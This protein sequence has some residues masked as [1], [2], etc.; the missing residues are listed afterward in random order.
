VNRAWLAPVLA[1]ALLAV[2]VTLQVLTPEERLPPEDRL[3]LLDIFFGL[4]FVGYAAVGALIVARHPRNA[5]GWLFC[6]VGVALPVTSVFYAYATYGLITD[7][8]PADELAAWVFA[9]SGDSL[10]ILIV[11][12][13][14]LFP[15]G[16]F[17]SPGWARFGKATLALAAFSAL[18]TA[19]DPGP[20]YNFDGVLTVVNP[21]GVDAAA[22]VLDVLGGTREVF[23][24]A[25][26]V[27]AVSL[28]A[29]YRAA[30]AIERQQIKWLAAAVAFSAVMVLI[31]G[32]LEASIE[33]FEG[34]TEVV[35]SM[36]ALL[37]LVPIP[38]GVA[39][40]MLRH[41][42]YDVDVVI[43]RTLI[44]AA[45]TATLAAGYLGCVL[46]AQVII[47]AKSSFAIAVSTLAMAALFRPARARIQELVDRRFFR[48]RYDAALTL[49]AFGGRLRDELDLDAVGADLRAVARETMQ[50]AHVSLWLRGAP[51]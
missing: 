49:E 47:G 24:V 19:L 31:L 26:V 13:M 27:A 16:R 15:T 30:G 46:L 29:R 22:G 11:L 37:A 8:L 51:R 21:L 9:W 17:A 20:L 25:F 32:V 36:V 5:V 18:V 45:L 4:A 3:D 12:L 1:A 28:L 14:L 48:R 33:T 34:L 2:T 41:R 38:A 50:P 44:Y 42:L 23:L 39:I 35:T 7:G 40:A 43:R 6:A 10:L